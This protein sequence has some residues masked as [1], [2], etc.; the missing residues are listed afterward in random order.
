MPFCPLDKE[1]ELIPFKKGFYS[2]CGFNKLPFELLRCPR[3]NLV[4]NK[5]IPS[6]EV[7]QTSRDESDHFV[8][9]L[10][11]PWYDLLLRFL[12]HH[13]SS[14]SL[15][16]LGC[17]NGVFIDLAAKAG[18]QVQ[19]VEID[20]VAAQEALRL[21]RPVIQGDFTKMDFPKKYDVIIMNHV[22][23][24]I[25]NILDVPPKLAELLAADGIGIIKVPNYQGVI[26]HLLGE[27]WCQLAPHTHIWFLSQ[28]A[29]IKLFSPY[30]SEITMS[31][32]SNCEPSPLSWVDPKVFLKYLIV[33]SSNFL[34]QGDELTIVLRKPRE[35]SNSFHS[36]K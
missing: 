14:G 8:G 19:G 22:L 21:G 34:N 36:A 23:E 12:V 6:N 4:V 30:F 5:E 16:E 17:N 11:Y 10:E 25:P 1:Q 13:R 20:K 2:R 29:V 24:H 26:A 15:L 18:F 7:Y 35:L 31:A 28:P 3:C 27:N 33:K 9:H 32:K